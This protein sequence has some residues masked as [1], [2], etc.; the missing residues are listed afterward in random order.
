MTTPTPNSSENSAIIFWSMKIMVST[1]TTQSS[2]RPI[3]TA[4]TWK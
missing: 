3:P 4:D 2:G 1:P